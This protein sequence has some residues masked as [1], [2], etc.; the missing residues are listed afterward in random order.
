MKDMGNRE[1]MRI[2]CRDAYS[3]RSGIF[4]T[5]AFENDFPSFLDLRVCLERD[6]RT[7]F[8]LREL[9]VK[10]FNLFALATSDLT[11]VIGDAAGGAKDLFAIAIV[12]ADG[13]MLGR[14]VIEGCI[15]IAEALNKDLLNGVSGDKEGVGFVHWYDATEELEVERGEVLILV[16]EQATELE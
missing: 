11:K 1:T 14:A 3:V 15:G 5:G 9:R 12:F 6:W 4:G 10:N 2:G 8:A 16:H 13:L 7:G